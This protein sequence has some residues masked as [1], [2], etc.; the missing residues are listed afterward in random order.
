M[1]DLPLMLWFEI[2]LISLH[3]DTTQLIARN[4]DSCYVDASKVNLKMTFSLK[5][6]KIH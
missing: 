4:K 5:D 1:D 2:P 6:H 3:E